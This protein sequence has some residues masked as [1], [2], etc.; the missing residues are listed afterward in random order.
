MSSPFYRFFRRLH[1]PLPWRMY[2]K[3]P[4]LPNYKN[5]YW[6][7]ELRLTPR[8]KTC[9]VLLELPRWAGPPPIPAED[10]PLWEA[11]VR[12]DRVVE[13]DWDALPKAL[14]AAFAALPPLASWNVHAA[15]RASRSIMKWSRRGRDGTLVPEACFVARGSGKRYDSEVG[16]PLDN[17]VGAAIVTLIPAAQLP[18]AL[19]DAVDDGRTGRLVP[20]LNWLFVNRWLQRQGIGTLLLHSVVQSLLHADHRWLA[21]TLMLDNAASMLW[22]WRN[23]FIM[24]SDGYRSLRRARQAG[25]G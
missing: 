6:D 25:P 5:E 11:P 10:Q 12:I 24:P 2:E 23:G 14:Q 8:P 3:L 16:D 13:G 17:V 9:D 7:G 20:H 15:A 21:S 19:D 22:H 4:R 18:G 1:H